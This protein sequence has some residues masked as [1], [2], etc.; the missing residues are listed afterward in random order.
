M[1]ESI[2]IWF[3]LAF[4]AGLGGYLFYQSRPA[5]KTLCAAVLLPVVI[6]A[7]GL[8][9]YYGIDTD[10]KSLHRTLDGLA[11]AIVSGNVDN[12]L[13]NYVSPGAD[14]TRALARVN[15]ALVK[16]SSAKYRDLTFEVNP[17]TSP[18][19]AKV[20][21]TAVFY[22]MSKGSIG[23]FSMDKPVPEIVKFDVEMEKTDRNSWQITNNCHFT[24]RATP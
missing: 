22:W 1:F 17:L 18:P 8:S 21:F 13:D 7:V 19:T 23:G 3:G 5:A 14:K 9:V 6:L 4:F 24:P 10:G 15:M 11:A 16:I 2:W 20:Q 12:V